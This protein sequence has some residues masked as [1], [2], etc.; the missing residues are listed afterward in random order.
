MN[1]KT[2]RSEV[3]QSLQEYLVCPVDCCLG[4]A[5]HNGGMV[6]WF[7]HASLALLIYVLATFTLLLGYN[8]YSVC[9]AM[10]VQLGGDRFSRGDGIGAADRCICS[11]AARSDH[12]RHDGQRNPR[13]NQ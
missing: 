1:R 3:K 12:V 7:Y 4:A 5:L 2:G 6:G 11:L 13:Q 10:P 8:R 9:G